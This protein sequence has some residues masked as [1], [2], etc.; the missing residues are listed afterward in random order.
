MGDRR[1]IL[2]M[3]PQTAHKGMN[4]WDG[5]EMHRCFPL[6]HAISGLLFSFYYKYIFD[7]L[8][9]EQKARGGWAAD[10]VPAD[11]D[12]TSS[13][14]GCDNHHTLEYVPFL[15]RDTGILEALRQYEGLGDYMTSVQWNNRRRKKMDGAGRTLETS[16]LSWWLATQKTWKEQDGW[17]IRRPA[18]VYYR[19]STQ[20]TAKT[21]HILRENRGCWK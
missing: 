21:A 8:E 16:W 6:R 1:I 19:L 17:R 7:A 5:P 10:V 2:W 18:D 11:V 13:V 14:W 20:L 3:C 9:A 12:S 4:G 15:W